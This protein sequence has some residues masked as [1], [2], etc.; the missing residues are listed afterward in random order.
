MRALSPCSQ[1][2]T[3]TSCPKPHSPLALPEPAYEGHLFSTAK[4]QQSTGIKRGEKIKWAELTQNLY[5]VFLPL[6]LWAG[7][8]KSYS[9]F[10]VEGTQDLKEV[11]VRDM[12]YFFFFP[13]HFLLAG[14]IK[15]KSS[16]ETNRWT[17]YLSLNLLSCKADV[18]SLMYIT[19]VF[20]KNLRLCI[21]NCILFFSYL[22]SIA[23][24]FQHRTIINT[25]LRHC[26]G[27]SEV[28]RAVSMMSH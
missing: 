7:V 3:P 25:S 16:Q 18:R 14:I 15:Q 13:I 20:C 23:T 4:C 6:T 21:W 17:K 19:S 8:Y 9:P 12:Q 27:F 2:S 1:A 5:K 22:L 24:S 26:S 11:I 28:V 10:T